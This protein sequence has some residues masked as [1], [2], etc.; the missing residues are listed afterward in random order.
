M[1]G[2]FFGLVGLIGLTYTIGSWASGSV[3]AGWTS[4]T[5]IILIL[6]SGQLFVLGILGEY[7]GRLYMES[8]GRPL[9]IIEEVLHFRDDSSDRQ[10]LGS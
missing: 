10:F 9:F 7:V 8:K 4:A 3:V 2:M 1:L 6:G 5:S